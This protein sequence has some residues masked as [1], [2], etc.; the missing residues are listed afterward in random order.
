MT[1]IDSIAFE[2]E[3]TF[4]TS[5]SSGKGG[6]NVNKVETKVELLFDIAASLLFSD[7]EKETL[8]RKLATRLTQ[9]GVL[10]VS[11]E[12][13]RS[14]AKNKQIAIAKTISI[15]EK[16]LKPVKPRKA[17]K[18]TVS[19]VEKRLKTKQVHAEKKLNRKPIV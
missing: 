12:E 19:S 8:F 10:Q 9:E 16:V 6:Q 5:R 13:E 1:T 3:C 7:V 4:R 14:Q 11:C 2:K 18:P 15:L 17:T